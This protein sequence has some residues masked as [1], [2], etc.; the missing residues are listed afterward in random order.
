MLLD[1]QHLPPFLFVNGY[2]PPLIFPIPMVVFLGSGYTGTITIVVVN[3]T[4]LRPFGIIATNTI[5]VWGRMSH[6]MTDVESD[7]FCLR[8]LIYTFHV[9]SFLFYN[10]FLPVYDID[11]GREAGGV[12]RSTANHLTIYIIHILSS[13]RCFPE[14]GAVGRNVVDTGRSLIESV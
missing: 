3:L 2:S 5:L 14:A 9:C 6:Q 13:Q 1:F 7:V 12:C 4:R 8:T 11:A 10:Q